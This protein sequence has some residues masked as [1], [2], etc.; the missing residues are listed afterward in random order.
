MR[1]LL[2]SKPNTYGVALRGMGGEC[3]C[4]VYLLT[5]YEQFRRNAF[6]EGRAKQIDWRWWN[7][8]AGPA[9]SEHNSMIKTAVDELPRGA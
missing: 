5:L 1:D 8:H 9:D 7:I 4:Q 6:V 3:I 2:L